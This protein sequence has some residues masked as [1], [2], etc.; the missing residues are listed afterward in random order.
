MNVLGRSIK[1]IAIIVG[2]VIL[3]FLVVVFNTRMANQRELVAQ[4]EKI[5][6]EIAVLRQTEA[7][8]EAQIAYA[9][10]DA[11]V[12][13]WAYQEARW[14]REGDYPVVPVS[15]SDSLPEAAPVATPEPIV[16]AN[17]QVWWALFFD[18]LPDT[19]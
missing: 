14:V 13:E 10:S 6:A 1:Y 2:L 8:L 16:Y 11:A 19:Q 15:P 12:E 18:D 7:S 5:Q 17:W 9:T 3:V 4:S